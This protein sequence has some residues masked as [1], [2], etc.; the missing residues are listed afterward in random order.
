MKKVQTILLFYLLGLL[1]ISQA[2]NKSVSIGTLTPDNSAILD[3]ESTS[4]GFLMTRLDSLG[5]NAIGTPAKGLIVFNHQDECYWYKKANHWV[6]LCSTDS[7]VNLFINTKYLKADTIINNYISGNTA[8]FDTILSNYIKTNSIYGDS[9]IFNILNAHYSKLDTIFNTYLVSQHIK[10]DTIINQYFSGRIINGDTI[11]SKFFAGGNANLDTIINQYLTSKLVRTDSLL[12]NGQTIQN[13]ITNAIDS[14]AWLLRGNTG[15]NPAINYLGT[16]DNQD[17]VFRTNNTERIHLLKTGEA[18]FG[19]NAPISAVDIQGQITLR[20]GAASGSILQSDVNGTG[21]WQSV[22][23]IVNNTFLNNLSWGLLGNSGTSPATNF[24]GTTDANDLVFKSFN[25]EGLRLQVGGNVGIGTVN[26]SAT[27]HVYSSKSIFTT[28]QLESATGYPMLF[29]KADGA[30]LNNKNF[31]TYADI[32]GNLYFTVN[33]DAQTASTNWLQMNR[34]GLTINTV[35]FPNGNVGIGTTA[36]GAAIDIRSGNPSDNMRIGDNS[37]ST[38]YFKIGRNAKTFNLDFT[39]MQGASAGFTFMSG[40]FGV[41]TTTPAELFSVCSGSLVTINTTGNMNVISGTATSP[42]IGF[43]KNQTGFYSGGQNLMSTTINGSACF[44]IDRG[45]YNISLFTPVATASV[46]SSGTGNLLF[47]NAAI[48]GSD[49]IILT[50]DPSNLSSISGTDN[51]VLGS[52][53]SV[54]ASGNIIAGI[55][56][57]VGSPDAVILGSN[58]TLTGGAGNNLLMGSSNVL[59][60]ATTGNNIIL[61]GSCTLTSVFGSAVLNPNNIAFSPSANL[62]FYG[63]FPLGYKFYSN[64]TFTAGVEVAAGGGSWASISD[65]N[66]KENI[67]ELNYQDVLSAFC[68]LPVAQWSYISQRPD[69]E[70]K[71]NQYKVQPKHIGVMAQDFKAAFGYGEFENRITDSDLMGVLSASV[72]ALNEKTNK[73]DNLQ[74][75]VSALTFL[76]NKLIGQNAQDK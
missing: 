15:T 53:V 43:N 12:I 29:L 7:L 64:T 30:G 49:N 50:A 47:G 76:V 55:A 18:G 22:S 65:R 9:A 42:A 35:C 70:G 13:V 36:P 72:V 21:S 16:A 14:T 4:Q 74:K 38:S 71:Y 5:I 24:V 3:L 69:P 48:A 17:L 1:T 41:G 37:S 39:S 10:A 62:T 58:N 57:S 33:N 26:P 54:T 28:L 56:N 59:S 19:T 45:N 61:G 11:I 23:N 6:R 68:A 20:A 2:Q 75:Q 34:T 25:S 46:I 32:T 66:V 52:H 60:G 51:Y 63:I 8:N 27:L 44:T 67:T 73:I 40:K 31:I